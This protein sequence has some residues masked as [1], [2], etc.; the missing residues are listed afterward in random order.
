MTILTPWTVVQECIHIYQEDITGYKIFVGE[1][2]TFTTA[3]SRDGAI[4]VYKKDFA[5]NGHRVVLLLWI[6]WRHCDRRGYVQRE[7]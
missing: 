2:W 7:M 6:G 4:E 1:Y 5:H 3:S